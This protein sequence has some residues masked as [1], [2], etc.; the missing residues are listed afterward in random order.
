[1]RD[2]SIEWCHHSFNP[3]EGCAKVSPGCKNCYA[4]ERNNRFHGGKHWGVDAPRL[5]R[6]EAYWREPLRWQRS[7]AERGVRERVFCASLADVFEDRADLIEPRARLFRLIA[8]TPGLD[9]LLLTKRPENI[10]RLMAGDL[11]HDQLEGP[12]GQTVCSPFCWCQGEPTPPMDNVWLGTTCEDQQ[13]ADERIPHLL[14]CRDLA[15]KLFVS[16]EPAL[17]PVDFRR[18]MWPT[19]WHWDCRYRTPEEALAAGAFAEQRRQALV[20]AHSSF[21]DLVIV[22]G[23]SGPGARPFDLAWARS[24]IAQCKVAGTCCFVKQLGA[25]PFERW[26]STSGESGEIVLPL[27]DRKGADP[28]EWPADLRVR[29]MP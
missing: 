25:V 27:R 11:P 26:R 17:G 2:S 16:Y 18:F 6:S 29:E 24:T 23:E 3:W 1:M 28:A 10:R 12:T 20:S 8:A 21:I 14:A 19:H 22:G 7:A 5:M 9:W 15:A 4:E 13:R